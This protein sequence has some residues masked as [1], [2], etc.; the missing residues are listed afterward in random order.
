MFTLRGKIQ[1]KYN[2]L[3]PPQHTRVC[4]CVKLCGLSPLGNYTDRLCGLMVGVPGYRSRGAG[5]SP[6]TTKFSEKWWV[7][8]GV[9]SAS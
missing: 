2:Y 8:I 6:G 4:M 7:W 3:M 9:H 5:S 1:R